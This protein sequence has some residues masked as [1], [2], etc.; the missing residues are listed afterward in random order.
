MDAS[1]QTHAAPAQMEAAQLGLDA[2][3]LQRLL[4][5]ARQEC[6]PG[7]LPSCQLAVARAGQIGLFATLG[8]AAP[9]SRYAIF[10][11]TKPLVASAVWLLMAEGELAPEQRVA[12]HIAGFDRNGKGDVTIEQLMTHTSGFP[13]AKIGPENLFQRRDRIRRMGEWELE[14][15][16]GTRCIYHPTSAHWVLSELIE[17]AS[18]IDYR[19]FI[20]ERIAGPLGLERFELGANAPGSDDVN[21]L[22]IVGVPA[23]DAELEQFYGSPYEKPLSVTEELLMMNQPLLRNVGIPGGGAVASA[24]DVALFF[25]ALMHN[26][27]ELWDPAILADAT[28]R[29]R[30]DLAD[31]F[32]GIPASRS[33]G[34]V[35]QGDSGKCS[36][37]M[38][39]SASPRSFGHHGAGGQIAW[40]DPDSGISF[41]FLTNGL[42]ANPIQVTRRG[43]ALSDLAASCGF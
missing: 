37:G 22:S 12:E 2:D 5:R 16:P 29:V 14:W 18:G 38:G 36:R 34:L 8:E 43:I 7:K 23:S 21:T 10:S 27:G 15:Q 39:C 33:L 6:G 28:S 19:R 20:A 24:A 1:T 26:A 13:S 32:S 42:G 30:T 9:N 31:P 41:C 3:A 40:A 17:S 35:I 25:Q 11:V 4:V